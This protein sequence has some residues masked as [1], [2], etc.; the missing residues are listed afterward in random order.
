MGFKEFQKNLPVFSIS[1]V[2]KI[3]Q[4]SA[5][6]IR[7]YEEKK[8]FTPNRTEV[9]LKAIDE[10]IN[11]K[12]VSNETTQ[13][14]QIIHNDIFAGP[15]GLPRERSIGRGDLSRFYNNKKNKF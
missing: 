14:R 6:Q 12:E 10:I 2:T 9:N 13:L 7:Y 8:L 15:S 4:L 1:V 5:R 3:T 11:E